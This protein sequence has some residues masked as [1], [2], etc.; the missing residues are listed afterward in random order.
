MQKIDR[1][2][3]AAGIAFTSYQA[4]IGIR[5]SGPMALPDLLMYLPPR[6]RVVQRETVDSLFSLIVAPPSNQSRVKRYNI[7]YSGSGRIARSLDLDE[8]LH[9]L[10]ARLRLDV[11][12]RAKGRLFVHAGVVGWQGRAILLPGRS[13]AGK[14]TLVKALVDAG[15]TYYSDEYAVL[16]SRGMVYPYIKPISLRSPD[17]SESFKVPVDSLPGPVGG[18]AIPLGAVVVTSYAPEARWRPMGITRA[19]AMMAMFDNTVVARYKPAFAM[20]V[21]QKAVSD[22]VALKG[23]RGEAGEIATALLHRRFGGWEETRLGA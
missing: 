11:A 15:A 23:R 12:T 3:W 7:L 6:S 8:V 16:D 17:R 5:T 21:L 20:E 14:S 4:R 2:G 9:A 22:C 10:E 13:Y 18:E 1:L 19:Q